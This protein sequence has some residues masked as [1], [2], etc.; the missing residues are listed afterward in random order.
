MEQRLFT[1]LLRMGTLKLSDFWLSLV[2]TKDQGTTDDGR[3]PL[4]IAA[5]EG[6]LEVV[7]C[8]GSS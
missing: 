7:P 4:F 3:A 5:H 2:P 1:L 8:L 6:H